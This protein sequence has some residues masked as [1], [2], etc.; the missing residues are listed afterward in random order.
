M[1]QRLEEHGEKLPDL[2]TIS[3]KAINRL[4]DKTEDF[5]AAD[6]RRL[7]SDAQNIL[8]SKK[9]AAEAGTLE[10]ADVPSAADALEQAVEDLRKM[11]DEVESFMKQMYQ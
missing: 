2:K 10:A 3:Q 8:A 11:R 9:A 6:L 4:S 7:V 5:S 1:K